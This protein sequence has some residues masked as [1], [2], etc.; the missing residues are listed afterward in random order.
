Y[1]GNPVF[2]FGP[3]PPPP[4]YFLP[5]PPP[6]FVVLAPPFAPVGLFI[7]PQPG[8]VPVPVFC[9]PPVF[10]APPPNNII[11]TN[12]HN[13][14]VTNTRITKPPVA[15]AAGNPAAAVAAAANVKPVGAT[16]P[17]PNVVHQE[18][19]SIQKNPTQQLRPSQQ[20]FISNPAAKPGTPI[21]APA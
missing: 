16:T 12:I 4:V 5:P 18:A 13:T 3:P 21:A 6:D 11:F 10:V 20:A 9:H 17:V 14:T 19:L 1:F 8:F 2:D 7:L 15:V